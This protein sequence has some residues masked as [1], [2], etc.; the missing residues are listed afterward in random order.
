ME[1]V[2][3]ELENGEDILPPPITHLL[4]RVAC[5]DCYYSYSDLCGRVRGCP[6]VQFPYPEEN[7]EE[8]KQMAIFMKAHPE[9]QPITYEELKELM[10]AQ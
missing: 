6:K 1:K 3:A 10:N 2:N 7:Y 5:F 9:I 4:R 8:A